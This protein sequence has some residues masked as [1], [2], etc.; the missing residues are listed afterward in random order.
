MR[1]PILNKMNRSI[2]KYFCS[3]IAILLIGATT[4]NVN[5]QRRPGFVKYCSLFDPIYKGKTVSSSA[6]MFYSTVTRVDGDDTFLYSG[7]CNGQDYF[8]IPAGKSK[9]WARWNAFLDKLEPEK[10]LI[11]EI[12]FE[13]KPE[14]ENAH[15]FGSLDGW[16]R[17]QIKFSRVLSIKDVTSLPDVVLPDYKAAKPHIERIEGVISDMQN[18]LQSLFHPGSAGPEVRNSMSDDF[19]FVDL[20]GKKFNKAQYFT[21]TAPWSASDATLAGSSMGFRLRSKSSNT[22]V[23]RSTLE[24]LF[25]AGRKKTYYCD[26]TFALG[27]GNWAL[28]HAAMV[29]RK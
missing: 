18:F 8:A 2:I 9:A 7:G 11:L 15:L 12:R 26:V 6:L 27:N 22:I 29:R 14:V 25:S 13:G 3:L 10:R 23:W 1:H 21:L 28:R 16:T 24:M 17:A 20:N 19:F 5:G 4:L